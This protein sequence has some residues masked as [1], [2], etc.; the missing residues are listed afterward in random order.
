M[1][2]DILTQIAQHIDITESNSIYSLNLKLDSGNSLSF[3]FKD[4]RLWI[5]FDTNYFEI[6][7]KF[8]SLHNIDLVRLAN[9][10]EK[11]ARDF[12]SFLYDLVTLVYF[13]NKL[14]NEFRELLKKEEL[15]SEGDLMHNRI[16]TQIAFYLTQQ[17]TVKLNKKSKKQ[18]TADLSVDDFLVDI[19]T[20]NSRFYLDQRSLAKFVQIIDRKFIKA[21]R[22][23]SDG[24]VFI[25]FWS[26]N[27]NDLFRNYFYGLY[28]T[29]PQ[30]LENNSCYFVL[31][32]LN[33]LEDFYTMRN[34]YKF[35]NDLPRSI[36][37]DRHG[38]LKCPSH[39]SK[40]P[41][42]RSGFPISTSGSFSNLS[43]NFSFG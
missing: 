2:D 37:I 13:V 8:V 5:S 19:K 40:V 17:H 25:A 28:D 20:I 35:K 21:M 26:K 39:Y 34:V 22:Q 42:T 30:S 27:M 31:D 4:E 11:K 15:A 12:H 16:L 7:K 43:F 38:Q 32:G 14:P 1:S 33:A 36:F 23:T 18:L 6:L 3:R 9:L 41:I 24:I 10:Y 29:S